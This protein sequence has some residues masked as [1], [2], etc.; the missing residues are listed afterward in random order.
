[1]L[2]KIAVVSLVVSV[3]IPSMLC[4]AGSEFNIIV[5]SI[6]LSSRTCQ[7][8]ETLVRR[9]HLILDPGMDVL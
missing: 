1:M 4:S 2:H 7:E 8:K 3:R 6:C 9:T 5:F